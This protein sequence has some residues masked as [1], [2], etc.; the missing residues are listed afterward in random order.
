MLVR[1][2]CSLITGVRGVS[3]NIHING[4]VDRYLEHSRIFI[5]A[6]GGK[7]KVFSRFGR[8]DAA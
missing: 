1:G 4:I 2:N 7:E 3:D 6:A 5:F 8:L